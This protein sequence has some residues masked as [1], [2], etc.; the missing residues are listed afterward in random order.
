M[1]AHAG[2]IATWTRG[3]WH[4]VLIE[5]PPGSGKSDLALRAMEAGWR[6]VADDRVLLWSS[7]E[8][9]W[10]R[11]PETLS[12]MIEARGVG[13]VPHATLAMAQIDLIFHCAPGPDSVERLPDPE[14]TDRLSVCLPQL[15]LWPFEPAAL[16]KLNHALAHLGDSE[17]QAYQEA[18]ALA[19]LRPGDRLKVRR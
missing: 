4:G 5:G 8:H 7:G 6:L 12:G 3:R 11:A 19:T 16:A 18:F 17:L 15:T 2:L 10:G 14:Q 13:I 9:L 1:I